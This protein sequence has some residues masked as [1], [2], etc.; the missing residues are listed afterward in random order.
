MFDGVE[1]GM[2]DSPGRSEEDTISFLVEQEVLVRVV[3]GRSS[4][5]VVTMAGRSKGKKDACSLDEEGRRDLRRG[6]M[7]VKDDC[8]RFDF[9]FWKTDCGLV[10]KSSRLGR[11]D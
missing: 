8:G 11:C 7:A 6:G 9:S 2:K 10:L 1:K 5:A 4:N 3:L